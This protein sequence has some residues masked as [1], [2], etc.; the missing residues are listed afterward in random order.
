MVGVVICG[1]R[2]VESTIAVVGRGFEREGHDVAYLPTRDYSKPSPQAKFSAP[3]DIEEKLLAA[4]KSVDAKLI[5]WLMCKADYTPG[6]IARMR[7][8]LPGVRWAYHSF[9]DPFIVDTGEFR[10]AAEFDFAITC[11]EG[12]IADYAGIDTPAICL[13][14]PFD[15]DMQTNAPV[16]ETEL[17]DMSFIATNMYPPARF[18]RSYRSRADIVRALEPVGKLSLFGPWENRYNW[19]GEHGAP[20]LKHLWRG[21]L[22]FEQLAPIYKASRINLNSHVRPDGYL[23]LNERFT[24]VLGSG[25]FMMVDRV[26]GIEELQADGKAFEIYDDIGDLVEK[27]RFYLA[28]EEARLKIAAQGLALARQRFSNTIFA[29]R[30]LEFSERLH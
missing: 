16:K 9:D 29:R 13:Y 24:N 8:R 27:C 17:C 25:G 20:E 2:R 6:L 28:N 10:V 22:R 5:V 7:D 12:S 15:E 14:P 21:A 19:G 4:V 26:N 3:D 11:C 30:T 18:P 1:G 23:Y